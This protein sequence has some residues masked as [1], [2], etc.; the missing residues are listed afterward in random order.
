MKILFLVPDG[1]GIRNYLYSSL[2]K[3]LASK[4]IEIQLY[5]KI[6]D[7]AIH[8]IENACPNIINNSLKLPHLKENFQLRLLRESSAYA[9]LLNF[10]KVLKNES[11]KYFWGKNPKTIKL[12]V[13]YIFCKFLGKIISLN[14]NFIRNVEKRYEL[15]IK[16]TTAYKEAIKDL[17]KLK[18]DY[19]VNL[20]QRAPITTPVLLAAK[21]INIKN[22]TVIFSWDNVPKGRLIC[23]PQ[24]YF[25]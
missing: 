13:F 1:V 3:E 22:S 9:R 25:V 11:I 10:S 5:H 15:L 19:I 21:D 14:Y 8:E 23:R 6:S 7:A 20:H 16:S 18:P 17:E 12:K 4:G 2:T 24:T